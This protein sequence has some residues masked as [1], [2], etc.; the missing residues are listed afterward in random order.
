[1]T[2]IVVVEP[3]ADD[4][5][6]SLGGHIERWVA[7]G[8][9]VTIATV[10]DCRRRADD[11]ERY[12]RAVGARPVALRHPEHGGTLAE[13]PAPALPDGCLDDVRADADR[14]VL[15]LGVQHP[16]H[17][18]VAGLAEPGDWR[19][20]DTPYQLKQKNADEVAAALWGRTI[21]SYLRPGLRKW[22]H[23]NAFADQ[24]MFFYRNPPRHL[25]RAEELIVQ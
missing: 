10:F 17:R 22:R 16:E 5:F 15:P 19:Y 21:V 12:A 6:L 3:H 2:R 14:L 11:A 20:L 1:M 7:D 24:A 25:V 23:I 9:A 13:V 18:A 8:H 4:A